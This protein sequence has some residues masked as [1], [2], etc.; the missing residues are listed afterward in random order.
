W[1]LNVSSVAEAFHAIN[2][3]TQDGIRKFFIKRENAYSR[4]KV[5]VN[6]EET[7][8]SSNFKENDLTI[9]RDNINEIEVIPVLEGASLGWFGIVF[10]LI[11]MGMAQT[12]LGMLASIGMVM[13]GVSSLLSDPPKM[14][15]QRQIINPSSDPTAL[16]NSY[17]FNGPVNV[18]N[19]GGPVP[20]GYGRLIVGSQVIAS[21]YDVKKVLIREAGRVR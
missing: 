20:I 15:E 5:L 17:L 11:G 14:P 10:G 19:E 12:D 18:L 6:G 8:P 13:A 4:Y 16:A 2:T 7:S 21:S 3:Q 1:K 9:N